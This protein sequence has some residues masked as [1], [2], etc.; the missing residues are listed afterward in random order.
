V[1]L[2]VPPPQ[3]GGGLTERAVGGVERGHRCPTI[4][5][6][7]RPGGTDRGRGGTVYDD[8]NGNGSAYGDGVP[9]VVE[10]L[11]LSSDSYDYGSVPISALDLDSGY[12][13]YVVFETRWYGVANSYEDYVSSFAVVQVSN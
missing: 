7:G 9:F 5:A 13:G 3:F 4:P 10:T 2:P 12:D 11:S 6:A 1:H 8:A